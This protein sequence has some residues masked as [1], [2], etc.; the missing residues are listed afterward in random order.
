MYGKKTGLMGNLAH[1]TVETVNE[2][3]ADQEMELL[4]ITAIP[5]EKLKS[6]ISD[7][8]SYEKLIA[9][10]H[11]ATRKDEN[12]AQLKVRLEALGVNVMKLAKKVYYLLE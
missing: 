8:E 6:Q 10:V 2:I 1:E 11:E 12:I 7:Q 5:W 3:L 9:A 4:L